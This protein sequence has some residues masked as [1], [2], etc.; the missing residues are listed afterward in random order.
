MEI[1]D[2]ERA[3]LENAALQRDGLAP[4]EKLLQF[5][6]EPPLAGCGRHRLEQLHPVPV[7]R[8]LPRHLRLPGPHRRSPCCGFSSRSPATWG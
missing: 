4:M 2:A 8:A 7:L 5:F 1:S 6:D 3:G